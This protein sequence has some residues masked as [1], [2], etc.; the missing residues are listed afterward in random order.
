MHKRLGEREKP[1]TLSHTSQLRDIVRELLTRQTFS[2]ENAW[3]K[4]GR[5]LRAS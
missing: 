4:I 2:V 3:V 5:D 1:Q